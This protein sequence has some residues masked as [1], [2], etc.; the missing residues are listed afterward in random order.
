MPNIF[1]RREKHILVII[2]LSMIALIIAL[3]KGLIDQQTLDG[4]ALFGMFFFVLPLGIYLIT[5]RERDKH[6]N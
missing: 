4:W 5:D 6:I 1:T 3:E 2:V